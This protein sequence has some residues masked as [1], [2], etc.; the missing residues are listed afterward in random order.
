MTT[1]AHRSAANEPVRH[2][3]M[4]GKPSSEGGGKRL[5][6]RR[7][8]FRP[9]SRAAVSPAARREKPYREAGRHLT[10][11]R[12]RFSRLISGRSPPRRR[13]HRS[14]STAG[15]PISAPYGAQ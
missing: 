13:R 8:M 10:F 15:T 2:V 4:Q 1:C 3:P 9:H 6:Q 11:F 14:A 5:T 7:P 12:P